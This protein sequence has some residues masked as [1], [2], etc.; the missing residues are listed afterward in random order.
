[1]NQ[2]SF[3][4]LAIT[5]GNGN[6]IYCSEQVY[7]FDKLTVCLVSRAAPGKISCIQVLQEEIES[8]FKI[9]CHTRV[10]LN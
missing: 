7:R 10:E 2:L 8:Y 4:R 9:Y 3:F 1:M 6:N 5:Y